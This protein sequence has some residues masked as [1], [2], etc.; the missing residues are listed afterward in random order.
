MARLEAHGS[1]HYVSSVFAIFAI[2][3]SMEWPAPDYQ[4][5]LFFINE[6]GQKVAQLPLLMK[7]MI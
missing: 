3:R 4:N 7:N 5:S 2:L 6:T 1:W